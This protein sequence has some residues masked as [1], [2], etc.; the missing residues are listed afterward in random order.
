MNRIAKFTALGITLAMFGTS[1]AMAETRWQFFHPR[2]AEVNDRLANQNARINNEYREGALTWR[3]AAALH[4]EDHAIRGEE[5]FMA[6]FNNGHITPAEQ[7]A[8]NQ[9]LNGVSRQIG[10]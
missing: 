3:Q 7:R 4:R 8:L 1:A 5:R 9:Q 10:Y 2:R 6:H